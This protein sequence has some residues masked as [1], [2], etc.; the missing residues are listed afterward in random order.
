MR[1]VRLLVRL[2]RERIETLNDPID[3]GFG[4]DL[5]RLSVPLLEDLAPVQL[6]LEGGAL[7]QGELAALVD[8]LSTRLG[9]GRVRRFA[10]NDTHLPE[11]EVMSFPAVEAAG[12]PDGPWPV[13]DSGDPA[14]RP[15]HLFDPPQRIEVVAAVPDGPPMHFRWRQILHHVARHEGPERIASLWWRRAD[16]GGLTRDYYRVEDRFGRRFW[17]FRHGLYER[18]TKSPDWYL[19]GL[20]A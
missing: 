14:T 3:P 4:F 12:A 7:A 6:P 8:R 20:F 17:I 13:P 2:F 10:A 16:N 5:V 1:E 19:H 9:R 11:Q 15:I 18:E